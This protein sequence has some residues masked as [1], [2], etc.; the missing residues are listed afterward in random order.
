MDVSGMDWGSACHAGAG[1]GMLRRTHPVLA[2]KCS[3]LEGMEHE[4][5]ACFEWG[6]AAKDKMDAEGRLV[7]GK[8]AAG[9]SSRWA[10]DIDIG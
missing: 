6:T 2:K 3:A 10:G 9:A 1:R 8:L 4:G 5:K 7:V